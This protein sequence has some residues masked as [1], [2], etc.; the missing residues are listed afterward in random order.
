M[1][2][3]AELDTQ[4]GI[5]RV[6][7]GNDKPLEAINA[8]LRALDVR[9]LS[10]RTVRAYAFDLVAVYRWLSRSDKQLKELRQADLLDFVGHEK[11]RGAK[12]RSIN[13]RLTV[14]RLLFE[15]WHPNGLD[16]D[17]GSSLPASF[18]KGPGRDRRL[19][20]HR[21]KKKCS[22]KLQ[23]KVSRKL[24]APLDAQQVRGYL[25]SLRRYRDIAIVHLMLFCGLRSREILLLGRHDVS[26][27]EKRVR[28]I[29]KGNRERI[30][31]L[32]EVS[33][34]SIEQYLMHERPRSCADDNLFVCLQGERRGRAMTPS[35]LRSLFR[36]HRKTSE[37][38][39]ANPHR[40]RHT[41][42][43]DMARS[44]VRLPVIQKLM[45]HENPETTLQYINLSLSDVAEAY[46]EAAKKIQ[47]HYGLD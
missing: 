32:G 17:S 33:V 11:E 27:L 18:Y 40:F 7:D 21:I 38:A 26:L 36:T 44:G 6:I 31:P 42:G 25:S 3:R 34:T 2:V 43:A 46:R 4:S 13:R 10:P 9:G 1:T 37:L 19:G 20:L 28:V 29:G 16:A 39:S 45:G 5:Y 30:V 47:Q 12:P 41:F 15:F 24:I 22:L 8:F 14:C 35:G 23:V